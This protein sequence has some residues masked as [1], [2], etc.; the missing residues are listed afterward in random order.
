MSHRNKVNL[1]IV[2]AMKAGT[3]S[4]NAMLT[5]HS[6]IYF[7]PI[8]EPNFFVNAIPKHIYSP[9]KF[10]SINSYFEKQFPKPLHIANIQNEILYS[11]LFSIASANHKYLAEG[12][13]TYLHAHES[14]EKIY[15]YNPDAKIIILVRNGLKRAFSSYRMDVGLGRAASSFENE[16]KKDW[17]AYQNGTL[18]NWSYLGMSL[19]AENVLRYQRLFKNNVLVISFEELIS[20]EEESLKKVFSFLELDYL[21]VKLSRTNESSNIRF[22]KGLSWFYKTGIKDV[23]SYI[24]PVKMRHAAF[25]LLKRE[26][27]QAIDLSPDFNDMLI[28][29]FQDDVSKIKHGC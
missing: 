1:F 4:F 27:S 8:K 22:S 12:S 15:T 2:G 10:F 7:S 11:K 3:T 26:S 28:R 17:I 21:P 25:N 6:K 9:S 20:K 19:Y 5:Q 29:L 16:L 18:S 24:L 23:F 14:C 13:T